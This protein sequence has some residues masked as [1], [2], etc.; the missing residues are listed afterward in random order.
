MPIWALIY[1]VFRAGKTMTLKN[2]FKFIYKVRNY[3]G[4]INISEF[5]K[6][7]EMYDNA[8]AEDKELDTN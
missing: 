8:K 5:Q 3:N 4:N 6:Y 2:I 1:A 7:L